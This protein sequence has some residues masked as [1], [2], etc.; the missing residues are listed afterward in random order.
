MGLFLPLTLG[1]LRLPLAVAILALG[2]SGCAYISPK[3]AP[4]Q[5]GADKVAV[6]ESMPPDRRDFKLVKRL[7]VGQWTSA[8]AVPRYPS[9]AAGADDLRNHA[10]LLGGDAV[11]NFGCY[12][13]RVDPDSS[14][15]CNGSVIRYVQ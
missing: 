15:Y 14:Y 4:S 2:V 10:V 5:P 12:H 7:W 3:P 6:F 9:V 13:S 11:I 1:N 8:I